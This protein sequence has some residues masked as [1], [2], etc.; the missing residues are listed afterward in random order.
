MK[1]LLFIS[2]ITDKIT[3]FSY[4]SYAACK[5]LGIEFHLAANLDNFDFKNNPY[6]DIVFHNI[7]CERNPL[8]IKNFKS[9]A[10]INDII[11]EYQIDFIHCNTPTG[12]LLG[13]I[14]G[15]KM[16][17]KKVLYT[18]HGF[19]FYKGAPLFNNTIL[20]LVEYILALYTD[21]IITI[22]QED[23]LAAQKFK[24]KQ[25]GH[26][27]KVNGVGISIEDY[28]NIN[29]DKLNKRKSLG[30]NE[31]DFICIGIGRVE[32]NK[33]YSAC[34]EAIVDTHD[35]KIHFLI[36]GDG[37]QVEKMKKLAKQ[38]KIDKQIHFLGFRN[39]INELLNIADCYLSMSKREG[40]PRAMMEAM[41]SGLPCIA[42][43]IRG[44][45][46]L[47]T[48]EELLVNSPDQAA[49]Q[50]LKIKKNF[51][52]K[53]YLKK[54]NLNVIKS[55]DYRIVLHQILKIYDHELENNK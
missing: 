46:D 51:K 15:K 37:N 52:Y 20:K 12:G 49:R 27:Y 31:T 16:H 23:F 45:K 26:I 43:N 7:H 54:N 19:H 24:L 32:A 25:N 2:N 44:N 38:K 47:I 34:I 29:I 17:V 11:K 10:M 4:P 6:K 1:K 50:I 30:L 55:Y 22:N 9:Y 42:S 8:S 53:D 5:K 35:N 21:V 48:I 40:L 36:C 33:N 41:A 13:R 39:D 18:A 3:N 28:Q 14:C